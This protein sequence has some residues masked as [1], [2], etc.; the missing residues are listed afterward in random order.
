MLCKVLKKLRLNGL[1]ASVALPVCAA[2]CKDSETMTLQQAEDTLLSFS[3][4]P[5]AGAFVAGGNQSSPSLYDLDIIIPVYKVERYLPQCIESVLSQKTAYRYR[6]IFVDDGS[7]DGCGKLLDAIAGQENVLVIHQENRGLSGA[8]NTGIEASSAQYLL[9][10]DS[11]DLLAEGAVEAML[12]AAFQNDAALVQGGFTTFAD[13]KAP[14]RDFSFPA[15]VVIDPALETLPGYAWGKCIRSD[16][17]ASLRF[18]EGYWFEDSLNAQLLFPLI[19]KNG[20]KIVGIH[21]IL[22]HYRENPQGI[23]AQ[24]VAKP[25]ALDSFY[26]TRRLHSD[27]AALSLEN[28]QADYEYLLRMVALT[29]QRTAKLPEE[30]KKALM[31][32]WGGFLKEAFSG[33]HTKNKGF[34]MLE[35]ALNEKKYALYS[36]CCKLL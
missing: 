30:V 31:I 9:F 23:S 14:R 29:Y 21:Q 28:T 7:P 3:P 35:K 24:A 16:C 11:D 15:D 1:A 25:K 34:S 6:A 10:L 26:L 4:D 36:L 22:C 20:G 17:L 18:P 12:S 33:Y 8:R 2:L 5:G 19:R 27:R 13:G 32:A